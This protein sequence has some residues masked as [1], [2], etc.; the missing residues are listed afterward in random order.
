[1]CEFVCVRALLGWPI[2]RTGLDSGCTWL[3]GGPAETCICRVTQ[4]TN[5]HART[6]ARTYAPAYK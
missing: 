6:L 1:M 5:T 4:Q 3:E 2:G